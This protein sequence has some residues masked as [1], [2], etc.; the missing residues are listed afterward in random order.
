MCTF[1]S[2][3]LNADADRKQVEGTT[4]RLGFRFEEAPLVQGMP[5]DLRHLVHDGVQC[6]CGTHLGNGRVASTDDDD[7]TIETLRKKGWGAAKIE[8]WKA[9]RRDAESKNRRADKDRERNAQKELAGWTRL[10][11]ALLATPN[12]NEVGIMH[13]DYASGPG[14]DKLDLTVEPTQ[15][16]RTLDERRLW[17]LPGGTLLLFRRD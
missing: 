15:S 16:I 14:Y 12:V 7:K 10:L 1:I 17:T 9:Q 4:S 5:I 11:R 3:V 2:L 8:R 6:D 13:D